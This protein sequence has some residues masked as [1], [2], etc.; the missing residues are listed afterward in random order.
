MRIVLKVCGR[1]VKFAKTGGLA[2]GLV[3]SKLLA[4]YQELVAAV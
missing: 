4:V 1:D 3:Y 2:S